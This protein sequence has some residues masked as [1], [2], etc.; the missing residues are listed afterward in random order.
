MAATKEHLY[1]EKLKQESVISFNDCEIVEKNPITVFRKT[2][3]GNTEYYALLREVL[4]EFG[5]YY[6]NGCTKLDQIGN[7]IYPDVLRGNNNGGHAGNRN[8]FFVRLDPNVLFNMRYDKLTIKENK[9]RLMRFIYSVESGVKFIDKQVENNAVTEHVKDVDIQSTEQV[10]HKP[11]YL[12]DKFAEVEMY[13]FT[14]TDKY[15]LNLY[16]FNCADSNGITKLEYYISNEDMRN[17]VKKNKTSIFRIIFNEKNSRVIDLHEYDYISYKTKSYISASFLINATKLDGWGIDMEDLSMDISNSI[18][19][20]SPNYVPEHR[21]IPDTDMKCESEEH[22]LFL[23]TDILMN[24]DDICSIVKSKYKWLDNDCIREIVDLIINNTIIKVNLPEPEKTEEY[25]EG[26]LELI[27][28]IKDMT[29][30]YISKYANSD[31]VVEESSETHVEH[32]DTNSENAI[33]DIGFFPLNMGVFVEKMKKG[34][35]SEISK[36]KNFP[37]NFIKKRIE[38]EACSLE[39]VDPE[40]GKRLLLKRAKE[41]NESGTYNFVLGA[42]VE[43][44]FFLKNIFDRYATYEDKEVDSKGNIKSRTYY[45]FLTGNGRNISYLNGLVDVER[46][47]YMLRENLSILYPGT[48]PEDINDNM[49]NNVI[50]FC[51]KQ[52]HP[53]YQVK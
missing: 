40:T 18:C 4:I 10:S 13:H 8:N 38:Q 53:N 17:I 25:D 11:I 35:I 32:K 3:N 48:K 9:N 27:N 16:G 39:Y 30:E 45:S 49:V 21:D 15:K 26:A 5:K 1:L 20:V 47:K 43:T 31:N 6:P 42:N 51:T 52:V 36:C 44:L 22:T 50:N 29:T 41:Y 23:D 14:C 12:N 33:D 19:N 34:M 7:K 2:I 46:Y 37:A 24:K 28:S